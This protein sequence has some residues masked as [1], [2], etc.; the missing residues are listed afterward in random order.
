MA[1]TANSG[2]STTTS[3][4]VVVPF[5]I[6]GALSL[7]VASIMLWNAS[8]AFLQH[9]F[10]PQI[11]SLTHIM[12]LGW[13]T[14]M[15]L[16]ASH[17]LVPVLI[18]RK[19]YSE[20][21]AFLSFI[22]AAAG[23]P[24]LVYAFY[25]FYFGWMAETAAILIN[26][27]IIFYLINIAISMAKSEKENIHA[28]F[29]FTATL[30]LLITTLMGA[31][32]VFNFT[33]NILSR[34]SLF[35]LPLHA[36]AGIAGW[37]L[38]LVTG[39]GSR[40]IPMFLISKYD[41]EK[42]LWWMY[43]LINGGLVLFVGLFLFASIKWW[44]VLPAIAVLTAIFLFV[45]FVFRA[46]KNRLRRKVDNPVKISILSIWMMAIPFFLLLMIIGFLS[47]SGGDAR[48]TLAYG[49]CIFFGWLTAIILGMTF[50]TLPF[51]VW[52]HRFHATSGI[53]K[54][55]D[56]KHLFSQK[57]FFWMAVTYLAGLL[58]FLAGIL[59]SQIYLLKIPAVLL[60]LAA[61][62]YNGNIFSM[63]LFKREK[64]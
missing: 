56:P 42:L 12:A 55:P 40:L 30:W 57:A 14:M 62:L 29:I 43:G 10:H 2:L 46:Y 44:Y 8:P 59:F 18:E 15:I 64:I 47:F 51:I 60:I 35:Y 61:V 38:L 52:N 24:L 16:G 45:V 41:N 39:V 50:K 54:S 19:L 28:V 36:H 21:L 32:L 20:T 7:L 33:H 63:L 53:S 31:F 13:G 9:Y 26:L 1:T 25:H 49:F 22:F 58:L 4:N 6:Y 11:L 3:Y 37:F 17:Q 48:F 27:A 34:D 5:Y 23:I